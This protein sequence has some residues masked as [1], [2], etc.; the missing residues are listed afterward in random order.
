MEYFEHFPYLLWEENGKE[1]LAQDIT[2]RIIVDKISLMDKTLFYDYT[3]K[4]SESLEELAEKVYGDFRLAWVIMI[5]NEIFDREFDLPMNTN[6]FNS[7][8]IKKYG[9]IANAN[10]IKKYYYQINEKDLVEVDQTM[11]FQIPFTKRKMKSM[12]DIEMEINENKRKIRILKPEY[13]PQFINNFVN[14]LK[15]RNDR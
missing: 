5:V 6:A 1:F 15:V 2:I 10:N 12:Y 8:I 3:L 4:D 9:S 14:L 13:L 11:Y 7:Y